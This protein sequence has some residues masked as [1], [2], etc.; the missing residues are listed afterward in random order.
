MCHT[1]LVDLDLRVD[2]FTCTGDSTAAS[3][4]A[5]QWR[6]LAG[7]ILI[8]FPIHVSVL[9]F[10][11][12]PV[13]LTSNNDNSDRTVGSSESQPPAQQRAGPGRMRSRNWPTAPPISAILWLPATHSRHTAR[14]RICSG[15]VSFASSASVLCLLLLL[16]HGITCLLSSKSRRLRLGR[17]VGSSGVS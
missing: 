4:R 3:S 12:F 8:D 5:T 11:S 1:T 9:Q 16:A 7:L 6:W 14:P 10:E 17:R 15:Y 2:G 13:V